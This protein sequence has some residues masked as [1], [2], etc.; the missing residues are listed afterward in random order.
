MGKMKTIGLSVAALAALGYVAV[1]YESAESS[2]LFLTERITAEEKSFMEYVV[3][4][5]K[6]YGTAAEFKFR[7]EQFKQNL[8]TIE[9][10]NS[11]ETQ[12]HKLGLNQFSDF[13][14]EEYRKMLGYKPEMMQG[15]ERQV[16]T[17]D[18]SNLKDSVDW[19]YEG[20]VT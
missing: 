7:L 2:Q 16:K 17:F 5:G 8:A 10:H 13:T 6:N 14:Q 3:E 1:N 11:D 12:G 4:H 19:R 15:L 20:A 9:A 18:T